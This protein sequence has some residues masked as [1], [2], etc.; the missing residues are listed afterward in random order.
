MQKKIALSVSGK[1]IA[2][3]PRQTTLLDCLVDNGVK[4]KANCEGNGACGKC[5]VRLD[6]EHY[7]KLKI[8]DSEQD[9]LEKQINLTKTSRLA[10][11]LKISAELDGATV[12]V[13]N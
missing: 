10:C 11:Q 4:I 3:D 13:V 6:Q 2:A 5:H 8:S 12:E 7:S 9:T 1:S